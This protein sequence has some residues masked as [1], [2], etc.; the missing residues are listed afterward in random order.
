TINDATLQREG[1]DRQQQLKVERRIDAGTKIA[2][3]KIPDKVMAPS[4][5][6]GN[7]ATWRHS[8]SSTVALGSSSA[9]ANMQIIQA[10]IFA[11]SS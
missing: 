8:W 6:A 4:I 10:G 9:A 7:S 3:R 11:R 2:A 1:A 5:L